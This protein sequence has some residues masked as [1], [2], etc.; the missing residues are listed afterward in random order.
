[1]AQP[2]LPPPPPN[3]HH[4]YPSPYYPYPMPIW[5]PREAPPYPPQNAQDIPEAFRPATFVHCEGQGND[6]DEHRRAKRPRVVRMT[7]EEAK[8]EQ[9]R[10]VEIRKQKE[11]DAAILN[12]E[13]RR[14]IEEAAR[15]KHE[16]ELKE[17]EEKRRM[18]EEARR[19][20][21]IELKEFQEKQTEYLMYSKLGRILGLIKAEGLTLDRFLIELIT[22]RDNL[23][24]AWVS[25]TL[26][27]HGTEI[28]EALV[29]RKP[30]VLEPWMKSKVA[31]MYGSDKKK[32]VKKLR[33][34]Q[35]KALKAA[36]VH[37]QQWQVMDDMHKH[38]PAI[39]EVLERLRTLEEPEPEPPAPAPA[40]APASTSEPSTSTSEATP[41]EGAPEELT[42]N[43]NEPSNDN[44]N[45]STW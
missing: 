41:N 16:V 28:A 9:A 17:F 20:H 38:A 43:S 35:K 2:P 27:S 13:R 15:H 32:L 24:S 18:M 39:W 19:K 14:I 8:L 3:M 10:L 37:L 26:N 22:S 33:V 31:D 1:M 42:T 23:Q 36:F 29:D 25:K 30:K 12:E 40:P 5:L 34:D 7:D 45:T 6:W 4:I 11:A 21:E 44:D